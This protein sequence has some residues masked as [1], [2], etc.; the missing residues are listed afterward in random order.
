MTVSHVE[1][2]V[3]EPSTEAA[4]RLLLPKM[5]G[6]ASFAVYAHSCKDQLLKRADSTSARLRRVDTG[7]LAYRGRD[8]PR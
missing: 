3:E 1:V 5:L 2:I 7:R 6:A 4:L 8:R